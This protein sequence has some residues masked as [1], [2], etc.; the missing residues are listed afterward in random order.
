MNTETYSEDEYI[1]ASSPEYTSPELRYGGALHHQWRDLQQQHKS[2]S[3]GADH[4]PRAE[5]RMIPMGDIDLQRELIV[6]EKS[7][8]IAHQ[9]GRER[10]CVRRVYSA[11]LEGR[12]TDLTVAMYQGDG[13]EEDWRH[14]IE[15]YMSLR[16]P[17][18][19]QM[20]GTASSG[21]IMYA[22]IFHGGA[23]L[24]FDHRP[25]RLTT[26]LDLIPLKQFTASFSPTMT[27]YLYACHW[28]EWEQACVYVERSPHVCRSVRGDFRY[29]STVS[30]RRSTGRL[31]ADFVPQPD[32][33]NHTSYLFH[34]LF[35]RKSHPSVNPSLE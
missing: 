34:M 20:Y 8:A 18:I 16:H 28:A 33:E 21:A 15:T 7:G 17:N 10:N 9:L 1:P 6:S 2:L 30:I 13:A 24:A 22:T 5:F 29:L 35:P 11:K 25:R 23:T 32:L 31:C 4:T 3:S 12:S 14:D 26:E 27:V 19:V